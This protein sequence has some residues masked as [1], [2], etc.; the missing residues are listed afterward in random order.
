M[1]EKFGIRIL[2]SPLLEPMQVIRVRDS[3]H[4]TDKCRAEINQ[5]LL[6]TFGKR[7]YAIFAPSMN[8]VFLDPRSA[9]M[10]KGIM[11]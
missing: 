2:E 7:D 3:V 8:A 10:L 4:M 9:V 5:W 1:F 11:V 6:D